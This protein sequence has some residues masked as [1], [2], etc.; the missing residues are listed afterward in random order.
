MC[1]VFELLMMGGE[2]ARNMYSI[3]SNK[4]YCIMHG[5]MD[6]KNASL[7]NLNHYYGSQSVCNWDNKPYL[8]QY[9]EI[10]VV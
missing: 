8:H 2:A 4:E 10:L 6:V 9:R 3:D 1:T 7:C 5:P